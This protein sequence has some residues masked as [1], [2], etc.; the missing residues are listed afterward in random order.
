MVASSA[1]TGEVVESVALTG[2]NVGEVPT[3]ASAR[4]GRVGYATAST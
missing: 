4:A 2:G 1:V 3:T